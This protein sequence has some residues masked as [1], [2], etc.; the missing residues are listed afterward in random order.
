[1]GKNTNTT[2]TIGAKQVTFTEYVL[3]KATKAS[4]E[5]CKIVDSGKRKIIRIK[6]DDVTNGQVCK[7]PRKNR[8]GLL[9]SSK[10]GKY[11]FKS[12]TKR[13]IVNWFYEQHKNQNKPDA[14]RFNSYTNNGKTVHKSQATQ[15]AI[16]GEYHIVLHPRNKEPMPYKIT[17]RKSKTMKS[18]ANDKTADKPSTAMVVYEECDDD[19]IVDEDTEDY[20]KNSTS[21]LMIE[22]GENTSDTTSMAST[23]DTTSMASTSD[24]TSMASTSD[25][26]SMA[27]TSDT[28]SMASTSD[29]T[30]TDTG[31]NYSS[32]SSSDDDDDDDRD[33]IPELAGTFINNLI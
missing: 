22:N 28:T 19:M 27:S 15:S 23:S 24:T 4:S 29:T 10:D 16:A 18:S 6:H 7:D 30:T 13:E 5:W 14:V 8:Y 1:M 9:F 20:D 12:M 21:I 33:L 31:V 11:K 25:T 3:H 26:T 2:I 32:S 17:Q